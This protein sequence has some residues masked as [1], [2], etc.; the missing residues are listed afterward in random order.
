MKKTAK[1]KKTEYYQARNWCFTDWTC[2]D[3]TELYNKHKDLIRFIC[4]GEEISPETKNKHHQGWIQVIKKKTRGGLKKLMGKEISLRACRGD[5]FD[6]QIYCKKDN[7]YKEYG[8][9]VVQGERTDLQGIKEFID[10]GHTMKEIAD[11]NFQLFCQYRGGIT[12]YKELVEKEKSKQF[13]KV[14]VNVLYGATGTGK[15]RIAMEEAEYKIEGSNLKWWDGYEGEKCIVID[16]FANQIPITELLTLL[17]GY[18]LRL[19][20]KG[21]H[22]YALWNKV[23][24]T[25][26]L[27]FDEWYPSARL[28]HKEALI[29]RISNFAEVLPTGNTI[30]V[31]STQLK[32]YLEDSRKIYFDDN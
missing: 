7:N 13:R 23:Y 3:W 12:K 18:Q 29:R 30:S 8:K 31:G 17:D 11:E 6:N 22:T 15:T 1:D 21:G 4:W 14:E 20:I 26:N 2:T 24:I 19:P 9:F 27:N 10:E 28:M 25:T 32:K 16:E 5:E